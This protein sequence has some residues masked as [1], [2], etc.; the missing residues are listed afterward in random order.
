MARVNAFV[1]LLAVGSTTYQ[2]SG[3][4]RGVQGVKACHHV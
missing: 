1:E 3:D 2:A 4:I